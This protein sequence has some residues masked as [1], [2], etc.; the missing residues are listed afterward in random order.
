MNVTTI[1]AR[2]R[3][4]SKCT[5]SNVTDAS[6]LDY[7][8]DIKN[9]YWAEIVQRL[10]ENYNW[11]EWKGSLVSGQGEYTFPT[12]TPTSD[13]LKAVK[14]VSINYNSESYDTG[15]LIYIKATPVESI[16]LAQDWDYY[17]KNQSEDRPIF[18]IIDHSI[19]I[20]P[21]PLTAVTDGLKITGAR[22]IEDYTLSTVSDDIGIETEYHTVLVWG[23]S[24]LLAM[25]K[26]LPPEDIAMLSNKYEIKKSQ[27]IKAMAERKE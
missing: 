7:L 22:E 2:A 19:K 10:D 27:S 4:Y 18:A 21:E 1:I 23:L 3:K 8:N 5:T 11:Q 15:G 16:S 13:A 26:G 9:E 12:K 25:D 6:A 20:A 14:S 17:T 24:E